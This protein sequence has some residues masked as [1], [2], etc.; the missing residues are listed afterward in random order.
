LIHSVVP[1][2]HQR[3]EA[4]RQEIWQEARAVRGHSMRLAAAARRKSNSA[5]SALAAGAGASGNLLLLSAGGSDDGAALR[6]EGSLSS[7]GE[8][9]VIR[10]GD[11]P[12]SVLATVNSKRMCTQAMV[13]VRGV[14]GAR[15][16][17]LQGAA[18][19]S[20]PPRAPR[21]PHRPFSPFQHL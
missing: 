16:R 12:S 2:L 4:D 11:T 18:A 15:A 10:A 3:V 5:L 21:A 6:G 1:L 13:K 20:A 9:D 17:R 19:L 8:P 7:S 14:R